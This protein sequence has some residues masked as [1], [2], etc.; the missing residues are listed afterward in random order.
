MNLLSRMTEKRDANQKSTI[1]IITDMAF[2]Y[3]KR[4]LIF[5]IQNFEIC[6]QLQKKLYEIAREIKD[7][8]MSF[9]LKLAILKVLIINKEKSNE[10]DDLLKEYAKC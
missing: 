6:N 3:F 9:D 5:G 1:P 7:F 2:N 4:F 10:A 8:E